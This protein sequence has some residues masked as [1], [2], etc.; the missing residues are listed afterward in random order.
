MNPPMKG[1][2]IGPMNTILEKMTIAMPRCSLSNMSAKTAAVTVN[3]H[4]PNKPVQ[5][6]HII[7]VCRSLEAAAP[8]EKQAK[9]NIPITMGILR[10]WSS[11]NGPQIKG[12]KAY[13]STKSEVDRVA[14]SVLTPKYT[15][16]DSV[17]AEMTEEENEDVKHV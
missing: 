13:P 6:R 17:D 14:T 2:N 12:P 1:P 11:E 7:N 5:N 8:N 3:G 4:E 9:P 16:M 15:P 10:P